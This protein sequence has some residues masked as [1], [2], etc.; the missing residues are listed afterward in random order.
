METTIEMT[1]RRGGESLDLS[2]IRAGEQF[3]D[4]Y[5]SLNQTMNKEHPQD[6]PAGRRIFESFD[7]V[8][9]TSKH[10]RFHLISLIAE[11]P[12]RVFEFY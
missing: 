10:L 2:K 11:V 6:T 8:Q 1:A 9:P 12:S 4:K 7:H 3:L 5:T